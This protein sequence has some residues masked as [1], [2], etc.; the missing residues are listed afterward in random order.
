MKKLIIT[1]AGQAL[2][3]KIVAGTAEINFTKVKTSDYEYE[4][5]DI[6]TL[7]DLS[8]I[9][10][11]ANVSSITI[12]SSTIVK[13]RAIVNNTGLSTGYYIKAV[14]LY[15][16]DSSTSEEILFGVSL[17]DDVADYIPAQ[18]DTVTGVTYTFNCKVE[19]TDHVDVTV[20]PSGVTPMEDFEELENTVSTL[21][22]TVNNFKSK[23]TVL[24]LT[25]SNWI[26]NSTTNL[27][28]YTIEDIAVTVNHCVMLFMSIDNQKKLKDGYTESFNGSYKIYTSIAPTED[29]L[30]TVVITLT[31]EVE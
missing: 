23:R 20:A 25:S 30:A 14:G 21:S 22:G 28:E 18:S 9:K 7:T 3:A 12:V 8:E 15:A 27:Y 31:E 16:T 11:T 26:L 19:N 1:N 10:Q 24:T 4:A 29:I 17:C 6:P 5:S 2:I 13:V